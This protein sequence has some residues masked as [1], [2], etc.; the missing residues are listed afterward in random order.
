MTGWKEGITAQRQASS[1]KAGRD[2]SSRVLK[3]NAHAQPGSNAKTAH[4]VFALIFFLPFN[5]GVPLQGKKYRICDYRPITEPSRPGS[6]FS[7]GI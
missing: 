3:E 6:P 5:P 1:S 7:D 2:G 4:C